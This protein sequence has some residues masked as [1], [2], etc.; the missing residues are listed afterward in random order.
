MVGPNMTQ[1]GHGSLLSMET[2]KEGEQGGGTRR[3][4]LPSKDLLA[5]Y[6]NGM[7]FSDWTRCMQA[8]E[9]ALEIL[10]MAHAVELTDMQTNA[11]AVSRKP[12]RKH[13]ATAKQRVR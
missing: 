4:A 5:R 11:G 8:L 9:T 3:R 10:T 6:R 12:S 13:R 7:C 1:D 2:V